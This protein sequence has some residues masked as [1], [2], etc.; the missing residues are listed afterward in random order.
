VGLD[1]KLSTSRIARVLA[2]CDAD[3]VALQELDVRRARSGHIDQAHQIARELAMEFHFHP[4][5]AVEEERYGDAVLSRLPMKLVR[6][7]ALPGLDSRA[8]LEPRGALWVELETA[9][10]PL[11]LVN[12]HLGLFPDERL[13]QV[14]SLLGA[15][16]LAHPDCRGPVVLCGDFNA[17]P[18]TPPYRRLA[19]AL[20][21]AQCGVNGHRPR[22]TFFSRYP[23]GRIDHVFVGPKLNVQSVAVPRTSL[24]SVASDHLPLV[25]DVAFE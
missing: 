25:V 16:W 8:G 5:F 13:R 21:D 9:A 2:Q 4:A 18:G 7:A 14:E 10:G 6:A 11:H 12:T 19:E 17:L 24:T 15:D 20:R 1:G 22:K 23:L 3:V